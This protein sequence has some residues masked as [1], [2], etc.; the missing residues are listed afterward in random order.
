MKN[1]FRRLL[2]PI[3]VLCSLA[4]VAAA[5]GDDDDTSSSDTGSETT[6]SETTGS[7]TTGGTAAGAAITEV[8]G[9]VNI[10]GSSTVEPIT[11]QGRRALPRTSARDAIV[12]VDGPGTGDGFAL[13][14]DGETDISDASRPIKD[15]EAENCAA[16]GIEYTELQVAFDGIAVMTNPEQRGRRRA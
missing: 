12:T 3:A 5:C 13:F 11:P 8:D 4:L 15:T 7:E 1:R 6:G 2:F 9:S 16:N 14:C 10:S